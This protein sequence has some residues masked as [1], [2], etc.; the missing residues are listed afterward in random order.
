MYI[1]YPPPNRRI[2]TIAINNQFGPDFEA[3][4]A[5]AVAATPVV[6]VVE[7]MFGTWAIVWMG[8]VV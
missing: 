4:T 6:M 1:R 7:A 5:V 3:A 2:A 8:I